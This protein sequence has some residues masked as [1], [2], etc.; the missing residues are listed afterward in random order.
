MGYKSIDSVLGWRLMPAAKADLAAISCLGR[1]TVIRQLHALEKSGALR[2]VRKSGVPNQYEPVPHVVTSDKLAPV[3]TET[4]T[5]A[6]DDMDPCQ[7]RHEPVPKPGTRIEEEDED[8]E[9]EC[10]AIPDDIHFDTFW[11]LYDH[12]KGRAA[13]LKLW[14]KIPPTIKGRILDR[15][16]AYVESTPDPKYRKHPQTYLRG[17]HWEDEVAEAEP[18]YGTPAYWDYHATKLATEAAA[19]VQA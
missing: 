11:K 15:V 4:A 10:G 8:N 17:E 18:E 7:P 13:S 6:T 12:K 16:P 1:R 14:K 2:I 9:K 19:K 5:S 3:P